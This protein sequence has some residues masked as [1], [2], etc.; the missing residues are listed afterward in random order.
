MAWP[1]QKALPAPEPPSSNAKVN[2]HPLAIPE[3]KEVST[4]RRGK[5][6]ARP[7]SV[8]TE[9]A[10]PPRH[11]PA[12]G[13]RLNDEQRE[14]L[15]QMLAQFRSYKEISEAMMERYG[16]S[17]G[18]TSVDYYMT[19]P[20][21]YTQIRVARLAFLGKTFCMPIANQIIRMERYEKLY[22]MAACRGNLPMALQYLKAAGDEMTRLRKEA[23]VDVRDVYINQQIAYFDRAQCEQRLAEMEQH[24]LTQGVRDGISEAREVIS[25][26]VQPEG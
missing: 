2:G 16:F 3:T 10:M 14:F 18:R 21:W 19:S 15:L 6:Q 1:W 22:Q 9:L 5:G 24:A 26:P 23:D 20:K 17:V 8:P 13:S 4:K 11:L 12:D 25:V 7:D